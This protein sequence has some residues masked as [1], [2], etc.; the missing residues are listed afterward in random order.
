M[1]IL[2]GNSSD[3][4]GHMVTALARYRFEVFVKKLGWPLSCN[5]NMEI[6]QFDQAETV[7]VIARNDA[8]QIIG[9]A[10]LLPTT[11]PYLL[12]TIFPHLLAG[13][14]PPN[15]DEI[16]ELSR[17]AAVDL[18]RPC[19][20]HLGHLSSPTAVDL[21][22]AAMQCAATRGAKRLITVSPLGIERL[23]RKMGFQTRRAGQPILVDGHLI[24]ACWIDCAPSAQQI[25]RSKVVA[26]VMQEV[27]S[28]GY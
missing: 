24:F 15:T 25:P 7:Y 1:E 17:F 12:G 5:D 16:W 22:R 23:L 11:R 9:A 10:R 13:M 26:A 21:L 2:Y 3:L 18:S 4:P 6:D 8:H 20:T 14:P 19:T 27:P 28:N